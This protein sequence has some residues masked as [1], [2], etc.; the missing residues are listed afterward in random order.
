[1]YKDKKYTIKC[2]REQIGLIARALETYSRMTCGQLGESYLYPIQNKIWKSFDEDGS[3]EATKKREKVEFHLNCIK[4]FL[5]DLPPNGHHGVGY[6]EEADLGYEMYK[7]ILSKFE[8][9]YAEEEGDK[10][11]PNVHTGT[12]LKLTKIPFIRIENDK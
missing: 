10:Y 11:R 1:M 4:H 2:N 7:C 8:E 3:E 5:W 6:D 12:P 9:E